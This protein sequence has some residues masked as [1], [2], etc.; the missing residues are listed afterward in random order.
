MYC[1]S[2]RLYPVFVAQTPV[3]SLYL[4]DDGNRAV[5]PDERG[6]FDT[7]SMTHGGHYQVNGPQSEGAVETPTTSPAARSPA[8]SFAF[9][10]RPTASWT[11]AKKPAKTF[12]RLRNWHQLLFFLQCLPIPIWFLANRLSIHC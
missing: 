2:E 7:L 5:F 3:E 1:V 10:A 11:S 9:A 8:P 4:T 6:T 12:Q